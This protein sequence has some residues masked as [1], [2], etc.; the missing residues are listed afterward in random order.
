KLKNGL[1]I[2]WES[3]GQGEPVLLLMGTG[4]DHTF[5]GPQIG[6]YSERFRLIVID[7]RGTG[8]SC[9]PSEYQKTTARAMAE[10]AVQLL[11]ALGIEKVHLGGMSIGGAVALE[12]ALAYPERLLSLAAHCTWAKSDEWFIRAIETIEYPA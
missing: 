2:Y 12:F 5:W 8:R 4:A 10:D 9:R 1:D 11:D 3:H 6:P 7:A